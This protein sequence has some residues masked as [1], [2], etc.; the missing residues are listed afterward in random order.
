MG[1]PRE[2]LSE[3]PKTEKVPT[4]PKEVLAAMS[5]LLARL[6]NPLELLKLHLKHYHMSLAPLKHRT[7]SL[8]LPEDIHDRYKEMVQSCEHCATT[9]R[10]RQRSKVTGLRPCGRLKK[11]EVQH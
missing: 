4:Q 8:R 1:V 10:T 2:R 5:K 3:E 9:K 6:R 11:S 7:S